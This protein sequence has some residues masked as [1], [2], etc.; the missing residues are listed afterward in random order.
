MNLLVDADAGDTQD[1]LLE[2]QATYENGMEEEATAILAKAGGDV[3]ARTSG[4]RARSS[5]LRRNCGHA[6]SRMSQDGQAEASEAMKA[7]LSSSFP[8][9]RLQMAAG[10]AHVKDKACV[11]ELTRLLAAGDEQIAKQARRRIA[12]LRRRL[13]AG[14][15][16]GP[17]RSE[18]KLK[19]YQRS[20]A[21]RC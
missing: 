7:G 18:Q 17:S 9:V 4:L 5:R 15:F 12:D 3:S 10:L 2:V 20:L 13:D 8:D 6:L 1:L 16:P 21:W 14:N 11:A 19:F